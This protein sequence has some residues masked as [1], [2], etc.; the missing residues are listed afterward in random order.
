MERDG[1]MHGIELIDLMHKDVPVVRMKVTSKNRIEKIQFNEKTLEHIPLGGQ[2][3]LNRFHEWWDDRSVPKTRHGA[4]AAL[5]KLGYKSTGD[6]LIDNLA[7]SLTDCYWIKPVGA[8]INWKDVNL[9]ENPFEDYFGEITINKDADIE[10]RS[11]FSMATSQGEV[12]KK[13]VIREDG[14][15]AMVKGNWGLSYQQS[16]NEEFAALINMYQDKV[17]YTAYHTIPLDV[18]NDKLGLG[19]ICG[20]YTGTQAEFISAWEVICQTKKK[21]DETYYTHFKNQCLKHGIDEE[22][23]DRFL[24]YEILLDILITNT[25]RHMNNLGIIRDPDTL[26]WIGMAPIYDNGNSMFF[27][28]PYL[29]SIRVDDVKISSF[30]NKESKMLGCVRYPDILDL[31]KLPSREEFYELYGRDIP[32]RHSRI[33]N[34][35]ELYHRKIGMIHEYQKEKGV[36]SA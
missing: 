16:I 31:D 33:D 7:L 8:D 1:M 4:D 10:R 15:R 28:E 6:M 32:E 22:E 23:F 5:K 25:D 36:L 20:L 12:R 21:N 13:W 11:K 17:P 35:W 2:L 34:L 29:K 9:Y 26:K 3:N 30:F 27:N 19:C 18:K 14:T 24:S